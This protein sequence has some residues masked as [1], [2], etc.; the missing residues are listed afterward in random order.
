[1]DG[2]GIFVVLVC[3][4]LNVKRDALKIKTHLIAMNK[5]YPKEEKIDDENKA[6]NM[7][8]EEYEKVDKTNLNFLTFSE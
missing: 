4:D 8:M 3:V 2:M 7:D 1:M 5:T 6:K